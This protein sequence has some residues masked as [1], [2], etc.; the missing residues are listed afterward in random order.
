M[1]ILMIS[2]ILSLIIVIF[3]VQNAAVIPVHFLFWSAQLPLVLVIFCSV[4]AG[5]L[6]MFCLALWREFKKQID[7]RGKKIAGKKILPNDPIDISECKPPAQQNSAED[8]P[9][10]DKKQ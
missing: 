7:R 3:A 2:I 8:P 6:L 9:A 5:S 1:F 10:Q 4:F